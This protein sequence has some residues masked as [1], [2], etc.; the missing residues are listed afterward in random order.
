MSEHP[1]DN[2]YLEDVTHRLGDPPKHPHL[3]RHVDTTDMDEMR[4]QLP[5]EPDDRDG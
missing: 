3:I 2:P 5:P 1:T 4:F